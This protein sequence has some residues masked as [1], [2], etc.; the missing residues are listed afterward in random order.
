MG[1]RGDFV[2]TMFCCLHSLILIGAVQNETTYQ[3]SLLCEQVLKMLICWLTFSQSNKPS[4]LYEM[5]CYEISSLAG[6]TAMFL[7]L[8]N[9]YMWEELRCIVS[10]ELTLRNLSV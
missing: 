7:K 5:Y 8:R 4:D 2:M 9:K 10:L 6:N 3:L 1:S